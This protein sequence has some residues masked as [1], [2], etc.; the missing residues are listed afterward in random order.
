MRCDLMISP[1]FHH[2]TLLIQVM[3]N[4]EQPENAELYQDDAYL[5]VRFTFYNRPMV[6]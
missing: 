1:L 5:M 3:T 4:I 6:I 2:L